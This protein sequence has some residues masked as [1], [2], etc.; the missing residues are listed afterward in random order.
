M[1][2]KKILSLLIP[3]SLLFVAACGD[4]SGSNKGVE[5]EE[6]DIAI[7]PLTDSRDGQTYKTVKIGDQVWMAENLNYRVDSSFCYNNEDSNCTKYGRLYR[8]VV[9]VGKSESECG[10]GYLCSLPSGNIQGICPN[11]WHLPD[12]TEWNALFTASSGLAGRALKSTTGW[13]SKD[14][15][16]ITYGANGED[17]FGFS[18]LPSGIRHNN[19]TFSY[20]GE[21]AY[22]WSSTETFSVYDSVYNYA[23]YVYLRYDGITGIREYSRKNDD[24]Y[25]VRCIKD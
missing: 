12:T 15:D 9:A 25:S 6:S 21:R 14:T 7:A 3:L 18:A 4:D 20:E 5:P 13:K 19:N 1:A 10:D 2:L 23:N 17:K 11:G 22:Y 16:A 8:W 24:A